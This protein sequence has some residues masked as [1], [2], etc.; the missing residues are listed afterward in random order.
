MRVVKLV[1]GEVGL[2]IERLSVIKLSIFQLVAS[3][4]SAH[5]ALFNCLNTSA[6]MESKRYIPLFTS[7]L[8]CSCF[9]SD[10]GRS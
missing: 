1:N 3:D 10:C 9:S 5:Q 6:R 4:V 7:Y 8:W 2:P